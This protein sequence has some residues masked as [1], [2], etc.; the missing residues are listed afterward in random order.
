MKIAV[1]GAHSCGK[2]T[3][4]YSLA[5]H[6]KNLGKSV[7]IV[8]EQARLC[9]FPLD[10]PRAGKWILFSTIKNE[11]ELEKGHDIVICDRSSADSI[12]YGRANGN[13]LPKYLRCMAYDHLDTYD[14]II[15]LAPSAPIVNDGFRHTCENYRTLV[16]EGFKD[17]FGEGRKFHKPDYEQFIPNKS[18]AR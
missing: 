3:L 6:Y 17:V 16:A 8:T 14:H 10:D 13:P 12:I 18:K 5:A 9:P 11:I 4:S 7:G 1:I 15:H 2:T